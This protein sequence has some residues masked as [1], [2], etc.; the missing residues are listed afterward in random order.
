VSV[1]KKILQKY[2]S[3]AALSIAIMALPFSTKV[4]HAALLIFLLSWICEEG[5]RDKFLIIKRSILLQ[6][7]IALFVI[8]ALSVFYSNTSGWSELEKK[9]FLL[10]VPVA[11]AT[12]MLKPTTREIQKM[13]YLFVAS[14]FVGTVICLGNAVY[15]LNLFTEGLASS[16]NLTYF[17]SSDFKSLN[18]GE[19]DRW[20]FFSYAALADG[21]G[22]HPTYFSLY[23][24][25]AVTFLLFQLRENSP[26]V[27]L[28]SWGLIPYFSFFI[29]CL[30]SR[31]II[32]GL[33]VIFAGMIFRAMANQKTRIAG[34][35]ILVL[36][37]LCC[38]LL[39]VNPVSRYR[40]LQEVSIASFSIQSNNIYKNSAQ[41][42]AS[43]W[44]LGLKSYARVNPI[45]GTGTADVFQVMKQTSEEYQI[46]NTL[47]SYDP[48]N[49]FLFTLIGLGLLG[50]TL[51]LGLI[52]L[53]FHFALAQRNYLF[54]AFILLFCLLC[55]TETALELQKGIVFFALF[56]SLQAFSQT[57]FGVTSPT[58]KRV[59]FV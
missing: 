52:M 1:N 51:L 49:Q 7:I 20:L 30:S 57:P 9:I 50:L 36:V 13:F 38:F 33:L 59:E 27:K 48:H 26:A 37:F 25:F 18:P 32:I 34:V 58:I 4:C 16:A 15:Q 23:I 31:I 56:F 47:N 6:L 28:I 10:L 21:I 44:W 40:N 41:I 55:T 19:S 5:W 2:V 29:V 12:S 17:D 8:E 11:L 3:L 22:I 39:Y 53:A 14:C 46:T 35:A 43:L 45:W 54:V 24:A 42:R